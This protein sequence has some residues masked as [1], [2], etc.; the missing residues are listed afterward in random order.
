M[1]KI[2]LDIA[3]LSRIAIQVSR[4]ASYR[5]DLA[6]TNLYFYAIFCS[7]FHVMFS[8]VVLY[9]YY[10]VHMDYYASTRISNQELQAKTSYRTERCF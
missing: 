7:V 10:Y 5:D 8:R 3:I 9:Y 4:Y 1:Q 2:K 6:N